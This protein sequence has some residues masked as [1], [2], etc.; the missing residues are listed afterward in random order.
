MK[1]IIL[2]LLFFSIPSFAVYFDIGIGVGGADTEIED[3]SLDEICN[4]DETCNQLAVDFSLRVGG[5]VSERFWI[6]G[7]LSGIGNRY[8]DSNYYMQFNSYLLGP[9]FIFYPVKNLHLS[10]TLGVAWTSNTSDFPGIDFLDGTGAGMSLTAAFDT[11]IPNGVLVG[12]KLY[13]FVETI[14]ETKAEISTVGATIF[15]SFVHK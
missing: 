7:E 13:S 14:E 4:S 15:L 3:V 5:Q 6:A 1:K 9:S 8:Y 11:G 10:G 2:A 12:L